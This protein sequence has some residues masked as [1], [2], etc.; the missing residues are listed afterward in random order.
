MRRA[1][2]VLSVMPLLLISGCE[3]E[4]PTEPIQASGSLLLFSPEES[5]ISVGD[6]IT[7]QF[8]VRNLPDSIFALSAQIRYSDSLLSFINI[9]EPESDDFFGSN[10]VQF[11]YDT[12]SVLHLTISRI[13][14][15]SEVSGS[16]TICTFQLIGKAI[17]NCVVEVLTEQ[18]E[19]FDLGGNVIEISELDTKSAIIRVD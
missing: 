10:A 1:L 16:G 4:S 14:G 15:Q 19:F 18:F 3:N 7:L 17:G 11:V 12:L 2:F 5:T 6:E 9:A 8:I 13:H